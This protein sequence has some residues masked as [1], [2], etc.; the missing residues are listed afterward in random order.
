MADQD[1]ALP[2]IG[3][4]TID[5]NYE[6]CI[7][8]LSLNNDVPHEVGIDNRSKTSSVCYAKSGRQ[9]QTQDC[10]PAPCLTDFP[11]HHD[12][13][14]LASTAGITCVAVHLVKTV[15]PIVSGGQVLEGL[16]PFHGR[17]KFNEIFINYLMHELQDGVGRLVRGFDSTGNSHTERKVLEAFSAGFELVACTFDNS[18]MEYFIVPVPNVGLLR[19][20]DENGIRSE[21]YGIWVPGLAI[22]KIFETG[23]QSVVAEL[24][25]TVSK[26][27]RHYGSGFD[28]NIDIQGVGSRP[29]YVREFVAKAFGDSNVGVRFIE[30]HDNSA[31]AQGNYYSL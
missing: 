2:N 25:E 27:H 21:G 20:F 31:V 28:I 8:R 22:K 4:L 14:S 30:V 11:N 29:P 15:A 7:A 24:Q 23:L 9:I 1:V 26:T 3:N 16:G 5:E 12:L 19:M 18:Q 13:P 10:E 17:Q 6:R